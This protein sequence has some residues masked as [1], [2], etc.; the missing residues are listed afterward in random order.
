MEPTN[1]QEAL[2]VSAMI[3]ARDARACSMKWL[4]APVALEDLLSKG[5][6]VA[7]AHA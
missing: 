2:H 5:E 3:P 1:A 6:K 4:S 7:K